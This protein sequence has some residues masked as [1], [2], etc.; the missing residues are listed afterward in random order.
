MDQNKINT[1]FKLLDELI[2]DADYGNRTSYKTI[3]AIKPLID[4]KLEKWTIQA[5]DQKGPAK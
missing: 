3:Q 2:N 4:T 1:L 5:R